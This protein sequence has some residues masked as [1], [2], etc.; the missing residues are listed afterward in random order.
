M[1]CF[2][3]QF[4]NL[5]YISSAVSEH[6]KT[7][8]I[9]IFNNTNRFQILV[10]AYVLS[11]GVTLIGANHVGI[12]N[13]WFNDGKE[14]QARDR[15]HRHGQKRDCHFVRFLVNDSCE[16]LTRKTASSRKEGDVKTGEIMLNYLNDRLELRDSIEQSREKK[17]KI[18]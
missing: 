8:W 13:P 1:R 12:V 10:S 9:N 18:K 4:A 2:F 14:C 7:K 16:L 11:H 5:T 15:I 6:D 3:F 17:R